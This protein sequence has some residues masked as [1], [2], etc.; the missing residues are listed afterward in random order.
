MSGKIQK[1][2]D[3]KVFNFINII[4]LAVLAVIFIYPIFYVFSASVSKPIL[5]ESGAV[6]FL[7][8]GFTL[9]SFKEAFKIDGI[10]KAYANSIFITVFGTFVNLLFTATGA[11]VLSKPR[12]KYRQVITIFVIVTMWF[13]PGI[14]PRYLN[15]RSLGLVNTYTSVIVGFAINTFNVIILRTFFQSIPAS[16]EESAKIDGATEMQIMR[17]IYLPLS[18]S[19]LT[20]VGLFYAVS[21]WNGYFWT[22][23]LLTDEGKAPLQVFLRRLIVEKDLA[24]EAAQIVTNASATSQ[25]TIIY[26]VIV[27]SIIP[28][29]IAYPFIQKFFKKG[30]MVGSVKG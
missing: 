28:M 21:R 27:V 30:V 7:P 20:T 25:Q 8:K 6:T 24:G 15:F 18:K 23:V 12:L 16:L 29:L 11:Y 4:L 2:M 13:D 19:A 26:A 22:M 17:K 3:E 1:T 9:D 14:I 10:W 5:V